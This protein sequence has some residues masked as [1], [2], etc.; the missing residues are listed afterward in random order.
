[1]RGGGGCFF[2]GGCRV[3]TQ[4]RARGAGRVLLSILLFCSL[5]RGCT[6]NWLNCV[7]ILSAECSIAVT[8]GTVGLHGTM[9]GRAA[10]TL[11]L[12][13]LSLTQRAK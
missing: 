12:S 9:Q 6:F 8:C 1:M 7:D 5:C 13:E 3:G 4:G 11:V 2:S 10:G